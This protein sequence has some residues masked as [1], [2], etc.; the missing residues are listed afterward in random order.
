MYKL[1]AHWEDW[2]T[3]TV[4]SWISE[5]TELYRK[6]RS[7]VKSTVYIEQEKL[8]HQYIER[9]M[10]RELEFALISQILR[11]VRWRDIVDY[12]EGNQRPTLRHSTAEWETPSLNRPASS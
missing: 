10:D 2:Q 1:V 6:F 4:S 12:V 9:H 11:R 7:L 8:A 5:N 3:A